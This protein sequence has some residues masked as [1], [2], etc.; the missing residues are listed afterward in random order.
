MYF[1]ATEHSEIQTLIILMF[2]GDR[3]LARET[4]SCS[5][6]RRLNGGFALSIVGVLFFTRIFVRDLTHEMPW[7]F[8]KLIVSLLII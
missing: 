5:L 1:T 6:S 7:N 3:I 8:G 4:S 2:T